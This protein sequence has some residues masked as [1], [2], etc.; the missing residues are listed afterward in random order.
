MNTE[1]MM[2]ICSQNE[3]NK[4]TYLGILALFTITE[5]RTIY[6]DNVLCQNLPRQGQLASHAL[7]QNFLPVAIETGS[8][9]R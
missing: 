3:N 9:K 8:I 4:G 5:K 7:F 1:I 2:P 6:L